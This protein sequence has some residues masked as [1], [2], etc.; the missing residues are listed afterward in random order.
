[1]AE[2]ATCPKPRQNNNESGEDFFS[3][4]VIRMRDCEFFRHPAELESRVELGF[5]EV[6]QNVKFLWFNGVNKLPSSLFLFTF[7]P[8]PNYFMHAPLLWP[9][10]S[11]RRLKLEIRISKIRQSL[12]TATRSDFHCRVNLIN[13][14][15]GIKL[16][17][18]SESKLCKNKESREFESGFTTACCIT[19]WKLVQSFCCEMKKVF[20]RFLL[21]IF[22]PFMLN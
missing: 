16:Q 13:K 7:N 8:A 9:E 3:E 22:L 5:V 18:Q 1:M 19:R 21:C 14:W 2:I 4:A 12:K 15:R 6:L 11:S 10:S 20:F 17:E